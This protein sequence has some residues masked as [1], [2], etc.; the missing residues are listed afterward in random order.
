MLIALAAVVFYLFICLA[1][2][3]PRDPGWSFSGGDGDVNN[4]GGRFGAWFADVML[5]VFGYSAYLLPVILVLFGWRVYK[6]T[7]RRP[8]DP[9]PATDARRRHRGFAARLQ[10]HRASALRLAVGG[11]GVSSRR[12]VR[13]HRH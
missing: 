4:L 8:A 12:S 13:R 5:Q 10:R 6:G 2:Y 3:H 7:R 9:E 11:H 1:S